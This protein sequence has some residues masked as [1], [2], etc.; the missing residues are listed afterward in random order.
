MRIMGKRQLGE[1]Q[2]SELVVTIIVSNIASLSLED[3]NVPLL[4]SVIPIFMLVCCEYI[5]SIISLKSQKLRKFITGNPRIVIRDGDIDQKEMKNLRWSIDDLMEQ[6]RVGN[7]FDVAE[8]SLAIVETSGSLTIY[9][10]FAEREVTCGLAG[11]TAPPE[12][13]AATMVVISDGT[14]IDQALRYCRVDLDWLEK[15]LGKQKI[16]VKDV[17][18]MTCD[19]QRKYS[20]ARY[21]GNR[22]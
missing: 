12:A 3:T 17:F 13:D 7:V 2:P 5:V 10:K 8:V 22:A 18:L 20:V 15:E 11:L 19:R 6:L 16:G 9:K 4:G 14:V 1:L 21:E